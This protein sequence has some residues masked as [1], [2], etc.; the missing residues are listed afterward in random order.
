MDVNDKVSL[1]NF[2]ELCSRCRVAQALSLG[3]GLGP[4]C[5]LADDCGEVAIL[6]S[7]ILVIDSD[8]RNDVPGIGCGV[9]IV[10]QP[11]ALSD[12]VAAG[13]RKAVDA[14][15][16]DIRP[17]TSSQL[18]GSGRIA[19]ATLIWHEGASWHGRGRG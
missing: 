2:E 5:E 8:L 13:L 3:T 6:A 1:S 10:C 14:G 9:A 15:K 16:L 18:R 17:V 4:E 12:L 7:D 11:F 19:R